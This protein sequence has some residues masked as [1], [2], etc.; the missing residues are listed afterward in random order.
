MGAPSEHGRARYAGEQ[1]ESSCSKQAP[2]A[3]AAPLERSVAPVPIAHRAGA[4]ARMLRAILSW[5]FLW[6]HA[7]RRKVEGG[8]ARANEFRAVASR[9]PCACCTKFLAVGFAR[10]RLARLCSPRSFDIPFGRCVQAECVCM[11]SRPSL[12]AAEEAAGREG[13]RRR[14]RGELRPSRRAV[15]PPVITAA[16]L[17]AQRCSRESRQK[18]NTA[19]HQ[20][21]RLQAGEALPL[22]H[23]H[24]VDHQH[25]QHYLRRRRCLVVSRSSCARRH[26]NAAHLPPAASTAPPRKLTQ[27]LITAARAPTRRRQSAA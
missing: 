12:L 25:T 20:T 11:R 16:L 19:N 17:E 21:S 6:L 9:H 13:G 1:S 14:R 7:T 5:S 27:N 8:A 24:V 15:L 3:S 22:I 2:Q 18:N 26:G 4:A 10:P 23:G